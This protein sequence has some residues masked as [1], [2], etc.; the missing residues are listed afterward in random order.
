MKRS[1]RTKAVAALIGAGLALSGTS[2]HAQ[3]PKRR[4]IGMSQCNLGE[5]WRQQMNADIRKA[6]VAH[7]GL[8]VVFKDAQNDSLVQRSH[9]EE[10][11]AQKVDLIVISPR[12]AA[13][14]TK[15]V[16]QAFEAGIPVI[17]LD[18]AVLGDR[19]TCFIGADN[20]QIG[21]AAG[22]W[23]R[24][25]LGGRGRIVE[26]EG[27]MTSTPG[28]DRHTGFREGLDAARN[29]GLEVVFE[30][31]MQWLEPNARREME[32]ALARFPKIDLVY[33]H[34]DPAAHGAWLAARAAGREK[35][36]RFVGIDA[37]AH[38]GLRYVQQG[39]LDATFEY[40][41]GGAEAI[42]TALRIFAGQAVEK[43]IVLGS[44]LYTKGN[45]AAGG[46]AVPVP[47][48]AKDKKGA[49]R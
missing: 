20:R 4:V 18:R 28:Q 27:L 35:E 14:L 42:E 49:P 1:V 3:A 12:E 2:L 7:P 34:N 46:A 39:V 40:P 11:V 38:E 22:E 19:F 29:P 37:L 21:R 8:E 13:A 33:A 6:A 44:R 32:S 47:G 5:P 26:L 48:A 45:V 30:A 25:T 31:D 43:K 23:I 36:M 16:A 15:P 10:L 24:Q 17:V 9:V 41:T